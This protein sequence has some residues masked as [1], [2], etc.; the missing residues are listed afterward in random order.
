MKIK[1]KLKF[2]GKILSIILALLSIGPLIVFYDDL[3]PYSI[4]YKFKTEFFK[5]DSTFNILILPFKN[6]SGYEKKKID[7]HVFERFKN[8]NLPD[9]SVHFES[10]FPIEDYNSAKMIKTFFEAENI[11]MVIWGE[12]S[13][14][15]DTK[16]RIK[17]DLIENLESEISEDSET[18]YISIKKYEDILLD[19]NY[20]LT[21]YIINYSSGIMHLKNRDYTKATQYLADSLYNNLYFTDYVKKDKYLYFKLGVLYYNYEDYTRCLDLQSQALSID[22]IFL[23]SLS[24]TAKSYKKLKNIDSALIFCDKILYI[25]TENTLA[26]EMKGDIDYS[27]GNTEDAI[28]KY[29]KSIQNNSKYYPIYSKL[30]TCFLAQYDTINALKYYDL[31]TQYNHYSYDTWLNMGQIYEIQKN[32]LGSFICYSYAKYTCPSIKKKYEL[33]R[34]LLS[35]VSDIHLPKK[36]RIWIRHS[37]PI[38]RASFR[39]G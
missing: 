15:S 31:Y 2:S 16:M 25:D 10:D 14:F 36:A 7:L 4:R 21:D 18:G 5:S 1:K 38:S 32:Y 39:D 28:L 9:V 8:K 23:K 24:L 6:L 12:H 26:W 3:I 29:K 35:I 37:F 27:K 17:W 30:A 34:K 13:Q 22:S 19:S 11:D 33:F 20:T